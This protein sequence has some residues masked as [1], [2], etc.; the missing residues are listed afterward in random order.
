MTS[1]RSLRTSGPRCGMGSLASRQVTNSRRAIGASRAAGSPGGHLAARDGAC[2]SG[3]LTR[4][5]PGGRLLPD[6][7]G[8]G[9][10]ACLPEP[11]ASAA[12]VAPLVRRPWPHPM[13]FNASHCS[14]S[15]RPSSRS[16]ARVPP[17]N[18]FRL[19]LAWALEPGA[20]AS[21]TY[22]RYNNRRA[23]RHLTYTKGKSDEQKTGYRMCK[24]FR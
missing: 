19:A 21:R 20:N 7:P 10:A 23:Y 2:C 13:R 8:R 6:R 5:A 3:S 12:T 15:S 17:L 11:D 18:A 22:G 16:I 4:L 14:R 24:G 9:G 1:R